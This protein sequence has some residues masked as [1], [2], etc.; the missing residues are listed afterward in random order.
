MSLRRRPARGRD[1]PSMRCSRHLPRQRSFRAFANVA[2]ASS[3]R[4]SSLVTTA[5]P[6]SS[7]RV[8]NEL[9][10][11][12]SGWVAISASTTKL[13]SSAIGSGSRSSVPRSRIRLA[14]RAGAHLGESW[15]YRRPYMSGVMRAL[16][17][18]PSVARLRA[19]RFSSGVLYFAGRF[20]SAS[21]SGLRGAGLPLVFAFATDLMIS[22]RHAAIATGRHRDLSGFGDDSLRAVCGPL[23]PHNI[24]DARSAGD[25]AQVYDQAGAFEDR[26]VVDAGVSSDGRAIGRHY[27]RAR[28]TRVTH[29]L[30]QSLAAGTFVSA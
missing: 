25:A 4:S 26:V 15:A 30:A 12:W 24:L 16:K 1:R 2:S 29:A 6:L 27:G 13:V 10:T 8:R 23:Q 11:A 28:A 17:R 22:T 3:T 7:I 19:A 14:W 18:S 9:H 20:S 5:T 21:L